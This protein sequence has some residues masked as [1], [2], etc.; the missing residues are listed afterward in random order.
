MDKKIPKELW[1][2]L[3]QYRHND[4]SGIVFGFVQDEVC[5]IFNNLNSKILHWH[6]A[7]KVKP[8][9]SHFTGASDCVLVVRDC[10]PKTLESY[11][12]SKYREEGWG[13][14]YGSKIEYLWLDQEV[15]GYRVTKWAYLV[16]SESIVI[17][18]NYDCIDIDKL[19][20]K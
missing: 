6:D 9:C 1:P 19:R 12:I 2:A 20:E 11:A 5:A 18:E 13:D 8:D 14:M 17:T 7:L 16:P 15:N 3:R 10:G 4:N